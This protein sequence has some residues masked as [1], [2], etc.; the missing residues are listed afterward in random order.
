MLLHEIFDYLYLLHALSI[1]L[2]IRRIIINNCIEI[3]PSLIRRIFW[4]MQVTWSTNVA[5]WVEA[6]FL[7]LSAAW[8]NG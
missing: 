5:E 6:S 3:Q 8:R 2:L 7:R 4:M 1:S